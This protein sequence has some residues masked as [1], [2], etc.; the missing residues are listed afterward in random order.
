MSKCVC[1]CGWVFVRE[2]WVRKGV[3]AYVFMWVHVKVGKYQERMRKVRMQETEA[4]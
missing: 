3:C 2:G 1:V 4:R